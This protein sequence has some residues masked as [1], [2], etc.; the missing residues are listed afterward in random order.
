MV[1]IRLRK[2]HS[3]SGL[4]RGFVFLS[5]V[6]IEFFKDMVFLLNSINIVNCFNWFGCLTNS[7]FL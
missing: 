3:V 2:F 4:L 6:G 5:W 1:I 7:S